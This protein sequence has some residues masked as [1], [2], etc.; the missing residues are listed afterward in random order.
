MRILLVVVFAKV[1][2]NLDI[3]K[4]NSAGKRATLRARN[5]LLIAYSGYAIWAPALISSSLHLRR[6]IIRT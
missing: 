5:V 3:L 2:V 1:K 6:S 4:G